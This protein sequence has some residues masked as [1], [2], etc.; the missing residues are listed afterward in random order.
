M[1]CIYY[2][3]Q[4][5]KHI[6]TNSLWVASGFLRSLLEFFLLLQTHIAAITMM[7]VI[8]NRAAI[9]TKPP[10]T[11]PITADV[12]NGSVIDGGMAE[13]GMTVGGVVEGGVAEGGVGE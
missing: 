13:G 6:Y 3:K 12:T 2:N 8:I 5:T 9:T 11:P 10:A 7:T 4:Q 1:L